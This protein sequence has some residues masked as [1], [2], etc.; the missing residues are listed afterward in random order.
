[1]MEKVTCKL[2]CGFEDE[3]ELDEL[4]IN[5]YQAIGQCP[6]CRAATVYSDGTETQVTINFTLN[7]QDKNG[8]V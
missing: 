3:F 6:N 5:Y 7:K 8:R 2:K 4:G 1:M